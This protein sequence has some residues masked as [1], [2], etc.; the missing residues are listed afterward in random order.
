LGFRLDSTKEIGVFRDGQEP[1]SIEIKNFLDYTMQLIKT[2]L[3]VQDS[4][5]L[6]SDDWHRTVYI[7]TLG[8]G[9]T[10]FDLSGSRKKALV[11]SGKKAAEKYLEWWSDVSDDLAK[12][13]P[14]SNQ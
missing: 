3:A 1:H 10:D 9:T 13:H 6:H 2:V 14:T 4:Q 5:H 12:N 8:V 11:K 7:D